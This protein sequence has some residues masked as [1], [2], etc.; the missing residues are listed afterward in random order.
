M[1]KDST[2]T[3]GRDSAKFQKGYWLVRNPG[4]LT[5][6]AK[7]F[8]FSR[9]FVHNVFHHKRGSADRLIETRLMELGAPGFLTI[10]REPVSKPAKRRGINR[11]SNSVHHSQSA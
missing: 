2:S 5:S 4:I 1:D 10:E 9:T 7:E 11:L 3:P 6:V 8:G